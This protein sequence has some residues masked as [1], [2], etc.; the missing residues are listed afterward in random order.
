Q[1]LMGSDSL[2]L[3]KR[4]EGWHLTKPN[5]LKAD[6]PTVERLLEQLADLRAQRVAAY[7]LKEPAPFGLDKPEATVT[8]RPMNPAEMVAEHVL[9]IGKLAD[10]ATGDRFAQA[11][12]LPVVFVLSAD[13]ARRLLAP[14]LQF[15]DHTL[16][17]FSD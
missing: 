5:D 16:A 7:P 8:L 9:K 4:E 14:P 6:G 12:N 13:F 2:E 17:Q 11:D 15:R 1:R 10:E 3:V